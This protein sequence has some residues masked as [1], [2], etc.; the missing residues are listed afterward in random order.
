MGISKRSKEGIQLEEQ[1]LMRPT[2]P[3]NARAILYACS[4]NDEMRMKK[5]TAYLIL[6][7]VAPAISLMTFSCLTEADSIVATSQC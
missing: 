3:G 7:Y 6:A 1:N 2:T 5:A 4:E